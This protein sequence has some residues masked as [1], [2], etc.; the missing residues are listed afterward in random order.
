MNPRENGKSPRQEIPD[1]E[2]TQARI[3]AMFE[4]LMNMDGVKRT[5]NNRSS[6]VSA[7]QLAQGSDEK[8]AVARERVKEGLSHFAA[9]FGFRLVE[10]S[11]MEVAQQKPAEAVVFEP[12]K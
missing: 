2:F 3:L 8:A 4:Q 12:G 10:Q 6:T 11:Q 5:V 9:S 7:V 1:R